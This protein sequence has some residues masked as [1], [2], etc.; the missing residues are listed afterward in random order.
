MLTLHVGTYAKDGG[1]GLVPLVVGD[2]GALTPGEP[3][4][5]AANA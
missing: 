1:Q 3:Y 2:D 4:G 5:D